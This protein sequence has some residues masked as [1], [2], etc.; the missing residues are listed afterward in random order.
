PRSRLRASRRRAT[1]SAA[2]RGVQSSLLHSFEACVDAFE[3]ALPSDVSCV[4]GDAVAVCECVCPCGAC[5]PCTVADDHLPYVTVFAD[6][7]FTHR[8]VLESCRGGGRR[9][10]IRPAR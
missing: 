1:R 7:G 6:H 3:V 9:T 8:G 2:D 4:F 10:M 5:V